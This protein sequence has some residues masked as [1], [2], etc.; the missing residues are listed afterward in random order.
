[1]ERRIFKRALEVLKNTGEH[2]LFMNRPLP[3][4]STTCKAKD[5]HTKEPSNS[6]S[7]DTKRI[8]GMG[9]N[10]KTVHNYF[11]KSKK[12]KTSLSD[13][14]VTV[15]DDDKP[16]EEAVA[17]RPPLCVEAPKWRDGCANMD[18]KAEMA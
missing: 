6:K 5:T 7:N 11:P 3:T 12:T 8:K 16:T 13:D 10:A 4:K 2:N 17:K 9:G 18:C 14:E 1:M 15:T